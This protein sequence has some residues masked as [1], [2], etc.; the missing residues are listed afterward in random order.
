MKLSR[1]T[2]VRDSVVMLAGA[3]GTT[4]LA[5]CSNGA[6]QGGSAQG[7]ATDAGSSVTIEHAFGSATIP[8][9]PSRVTTLAW[10]NHEPVLA[11]G[12]APVGISAANFGVANGEKLLPW[13]RDAFQ[14]LGVDIPTVFDDTDGIDFEA[15]NDT[16]PD[17]ILCPYSGYTQ[18]DYDKLSQIAPTV[19]Y[20]QKAWS[21]LW[22]EQTR[23]EAKALG[24]EEEAEGLI[25]DL[26]DM[27]RQKVSQSRIAG[28]SAAFLNIPPT[29]MGTVYVYLPSDPR[30][31]Y[32]ADL[33]FKTPE[34]VT[35]L[36]S[37]E[38]SFAATLSAEE[39]D[40]LNDVDMAVTYG[41]E[42]FLAQLQGD[43][44]LG[45]IPC[46]RRGAIALLKG[47]EPLAASCTP[48]PLSIPATIDQYLG[49]LSSALEKV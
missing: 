39:A 47:T 15:V 38:D 30:G 34:S 10:N 16:A 35:A 31:A 9:K 21:C 45:R 46:I 25:A 1:R 7:P 14:K 42:A 36:A 5:A 26:E 29:D 22:R 20:P 4:L 19:A 18:A 3:L 12:I 41:D 28:Q 24:K 43:P 44:L 37:S 49:V 23:I 13:T 32:L 6:R 8:S 48:G 17:V 2:F 11:L 27:V 40:R 33:G